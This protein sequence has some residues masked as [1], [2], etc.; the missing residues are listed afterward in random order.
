MVLEPSIELVRTAIHDDDGL[1]EIQL[2]ATNGSYA[3]GQALY[4]Y[5]E[6]FVEFIAQLKSFGTTIHDEATFESGSESAG[7]AHFVLLHAFIHSPRGDA[8]LHVRATNNQN[9]LH[10]HTAEFSIS[11]EP[12]ALNRLGRAIEQWVGNATEPLVWRAAG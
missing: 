8:A 5:P 7:W 2:R 9:G 3:A 12:G 11:A 6:N 4:A 10:G 1:W